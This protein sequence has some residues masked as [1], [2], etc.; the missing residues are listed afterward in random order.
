MPSC[1]ELAKEIATL[2]AE[3]KSMQES[4]SM[5][6]GLYESVKVQNETIL[7]ENKLLKDENAK[8]SQRLMSLEQY[9]RLNNVEV[10]GIPVTEGEQTIKEYSDEKR[11]LGPLVDLKECH[12]IAGLTDGVPPDVELGLAGLSFISPSEWLAAAQKV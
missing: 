1:A 7:K 10:K 9:S 12:I 11:R 6:I 2:R 5:F 8:L 3:M 4:L